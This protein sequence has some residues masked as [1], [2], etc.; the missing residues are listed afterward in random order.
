MVVADCTINYRSALFI[1]KMQKQNIPIQNL[2]GR[3]LAWV[4]EGGKIY[5]QKGETR[6]IHVYRKEWNYPADGYESVMFGF[7]GQLFES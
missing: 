6:R 3:L 7:F 4:L 2:I 5:D 1:Q